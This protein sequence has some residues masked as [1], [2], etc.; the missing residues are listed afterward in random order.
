LL[1]SSMLASRA[2]GA[3]RILPLLRLYSSETTP[4]LR[5]VLQS[6][7]K[8]AMRAKN[9]SA[10][11][12]LRSVLAEINAADKAAD[13]KISS[14]NI[15]SIIRKASARRRDAAVQYTQAN[16]PDLAEKELTEA[17]LLAEFLPALMSSA[18]ID[19]II[20]DIL[21]SLALSPAEDPR[22]ATGKIFKAFYS[23]VDRSIV[24]TDVVK[25]RVNHALNSV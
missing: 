13:S 12:T 1:L 10:S 8:D 2:L 5:D 9:T 11:T 19:A 14:S 3:R 21:P 7:V 15:V 20:L 18:E 25:T 17:A 16:R 24:D 22:K 4:E 23:K 6:R